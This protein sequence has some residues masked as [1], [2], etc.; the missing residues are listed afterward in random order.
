MKKF[1]NASKKFKLNSYIT[2]HLRQIWRYWPERQ[3]ALDRTRRLGGHT[4]EKC[5]K[6]YDKREVQVDHIHPVGGFR[7]DWNAYVSNLFCGAH[8]LQVLCI[9][10][11]KKK[12]LGERKERAKEII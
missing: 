7:G 6:L 11:H 10:C 12:T 5:G 8:N 1:A 2:D 3:L 4:C 9:D